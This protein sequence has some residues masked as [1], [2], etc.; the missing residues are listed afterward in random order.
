MGYIY[1]IT[2]NINGKKYVG[3]T[4]FNVE[5]RWSEHLKDYKRKR[6]EKRALY[7][8]MNKYGVENFTC[9][10]ICECSNDILDVKEQEYIELLQTYK[11]G[12]NLTFGGDGKILYNYN[13]IVEYYVNNKVTMRDTAT[14]FKC[15]VD[16]VKD[17]LKKHNVEI[18]NLHLENFYGSCL[19]PKTISSYTKENVFIKQFNSVKE[20]S[21]WVFENGKCKTLNSGVRGHISDCANGKQSTA[22][23]YI[24][25]YN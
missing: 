8:A 10:K 14:F 22:Y 21:E 6:S 20:A 17:I 19:K 25:K 15:S 2:N 7:E 4:T 5:K 18:R 16:T 1:C 23:G 13:N 11:H 9:E 12:Y 3:K 24:W